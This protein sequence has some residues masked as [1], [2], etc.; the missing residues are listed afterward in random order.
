MY[1]KM[2]T[3]SQNSK[4]PLFL[5]PGAAKTPFSFI[6]L[7]Q[8]IDGNRSVYAFSL[9]G[10]EDDREP[11]TNVREMAKEYAAELR[12]IQQHGPYLLGGYCFG[13]VV[14]FEIA[15]QL[16][17]EGE[18]IRGLALFDSLPP[19]RVG[20]TD[21]DI[22]DSLLPHITQAQ[23]KIAANMDKTITLLEPSLVDR[24]KTVRQANDNALFA[25]RAKPI[26]CAPTLFRTRT[27]NEIVFEAWK[28]LSH[29]GFTIVDV[30]GDTF[31]MMNP[32]HV[33]YLAKRFIEAVQK[34]SI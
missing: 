32:P 2:S 5:F 30:P 4:R 34:S 21:E 29:N 13:G 12:S 8:E 15:S 31:S 28:N 19:H 25:Y 18:T 14:A 1:L 9:A 7:S 23:S 20:F 17:A 27:F 33:E 6:H 11:Q 3:S 10:M 16:E 26:N 24:F 22:P